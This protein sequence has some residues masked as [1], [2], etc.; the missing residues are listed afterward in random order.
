MKIIKTKKI[1]GNKVTKEFLGKLDKELKGKV[2]LPKGETV[3]SLLGR[4]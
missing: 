1:Q 4:K 3:L 2:Q